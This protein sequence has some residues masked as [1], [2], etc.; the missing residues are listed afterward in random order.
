MERLVGRQFNSRR[1]LAIVVIGALGVGISCFLYSIL[2]REERKLLVEEFQHRSAERI[3]GITS[4]FESGIALVRS[5]AAHVKTNSGMNRQ[6]F[7]AFTNHLFMSGTKIQAL[8]WNARVAA[9]EL[10]DFIRQAREL[11]ATFRVTQMDQLGQVVEVSPADAMASGNDLIVVDVI[12]PLDANRSAV[13]FDISS[14]PTRREALLRARDTGQLTATGKIRLV[15]ETGEQ[16]GILVFGPIYK[17]GVALNSIAQRQKHFKGVVVGVYRIGDTVDVAMS[18]LKATGIDVYVV[19]ESATPEPQL[20]HVH[21]SR[22]RRDVDAPVE[23]WLR[24]KDQTLYQQKTIDIGGRQWSIGCVPTSAFLDSC[25]SYLPL[26]VL[27][28]GLFGTASLIGYLIKLARMTDHLQYHLRRRLELEQKLKMTK[29]SIDSSHIPVFWVGPNGRIQYANQAAAASLGRELADVVSLHVSQFV[30]DWTWAEWSRRWK[31]LKA[32]GSAKLELMHLRKN[33]RLFPVEVMLNYVSYAEYEFVVCLALDITARRRAEQQLVQTRFAVESSSEAIFNINREGRLVDV[34]RAACQRL[35]HSRQELLTMT[36]PDIDPNYDVASWSTQWRELKRKQ[37]VMLESV[38]RT[39]CGEVFPVEISVAYFEFDGNEYAC[40]FARDITQRTRQQEQI[41]EQEQELAHIARLSTLGE[42]VAGIAHE[43]N[44]PLSAMSNL[45]GACSRAIA[46]S[47]HE[48][49]L[50]LADWTHQIGVQAVRCGDII[51]RLRSFARKNELAR[52]PVD[53]NPVVDDSIALMNNDARNRSVQINWK[54]CG[55]DPVVT[56]NRAQ[57]QQ[58]IINLLRN[59]CE[60]VSQN[61]SPSRRVLVCSQ[62]SNDRVHVIV[63]DNGP[64]IDSED[65]EKVF[66]AFFTTKSAGMGMGLAIS[67]SIIEAHGGRLWAETA[68]SRG[69]RFQIELPSSDHM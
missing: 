9:E 58:V 11:D 67:R 42:M 63:E 21:A 45:A 33:G 29:F 49:K 41:R 57:L 28:G 48:F 16:C 32:T 61:D 52:E 50:P 51:R 15:Q 6:D 18:K 34:N 39:K 14:E 26:F 54:P 37:R 65:V 69:A 36:V 53:L 19:D 47:G 1:F 31:Q 24:I 38:H 23:D 64:G 8:S 10:G 25:H 55:P 62:I 4:E 43:I 27:I 12:E 2:L 5:V 40:A 60:A 13:G 17:R 44:Q 56:A 7:A 20:L 3:I 59:A 66:D 35:G 30:P 46:E 22:L 68:T